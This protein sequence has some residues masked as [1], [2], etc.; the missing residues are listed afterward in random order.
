MDSVHETYE[1]VLRGIL[2]NTFNDRS[3]L[4]QEMAW[5]REA[6]S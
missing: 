5:Y 1:I 2:Q 4:V 6:L 3:T